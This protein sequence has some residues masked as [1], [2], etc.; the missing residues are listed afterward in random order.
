MVGWRGISAGTGADVVLVLVV[1]VT[2]EAWLA[3][4]PPSSTGSG[5]SERFSAHA[6]E[7]LKVSHGQAGRKRNVHG[8]GFSKQG[9][10]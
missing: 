7:V 5:A 9:F 1:V 8:V 6:S 4:G 10:R 2:V 3:P